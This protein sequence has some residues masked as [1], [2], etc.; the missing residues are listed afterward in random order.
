MARAACLNYTSGSMRFWPD[1]YGKSRAFPLA[2]QSLWTVC[3]L[4]GHRQR[5]DAPLGGGSRWKCEPNVTFPT[6]KPPRRLIYSII[7]CE[8][9]AL[10]EVLVEKELVLWPV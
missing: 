5:T 10:T 8:A 2:L 9:P 3:D 7:C 6:R 1:G 4:E